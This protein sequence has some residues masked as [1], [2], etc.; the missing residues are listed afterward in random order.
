MSGGGG[1]SGMSGLSG[2]GGMP[3]FGGGAGGMC[4]LGGGGMFGGMAMSAG[5]GGAGG[6]SEDKSSYNSIKT[7]WFP[8]CKKAA[9]ALSTGKLAIWA[10]IPALIAICKT[11]GSIVSAINTWVTGACSAVPCSN[12]TLA[13]TAEKNGSAPAISIYTHILHYKEARDTFCT[14]TKSDSKF[15]ISSTMKALKAKAGQKFINAGM[16][17][18]MAG[19]ITPK[20]L[21]F[22]RVPKRHTIPLV[23]MPWGPRAIMVEA[24]SK[25]PK[26]KF[27]HNTTQVKGKA[28]KICG[29]SFDDKKIPNLIQIA[30]PGDR[31]ADEL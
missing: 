1:M 25:D 10:N 3:E 16:K 22:I 30:T 5:I 6:A 29:S 7:K 15:C 11:K 21:A 9:E 2:A 8:S 18:A 23:L 31:K 13:L 4:G 19:K 28:R 17:S 26:I 20:A 27:K 24:I 12:D 14:Q